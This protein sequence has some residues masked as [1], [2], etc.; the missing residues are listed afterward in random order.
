MNNKI[1]AVINTYNEQDNIKR[2]LSSVAWADE[3]VLCDMYSTDET[4]A[5]AKKMG[6]KV[7]YHKNVGFVEPARNFAISKAIGDWILIIDADEEI[8]KT[9]ADYLKKTAKENKDINYVEI[10]RKNIIFG[11]WMQASMWWPDYHPRFFRKG[12]VIWNEKIHSKPNASGKKLTLDPEEQNTIIHHHYTN[13]AQFISRM[14]RYTDI[15]AKELHEAGYEFQWQDLITKPVNEFLG[16]FF[17]NKGFNDGLHG[18]SLSFLQSFSHLVMYLKVWEL[19]SF[20]QI[21]IKLKDIEKS[22]NSS[23][24]ELNYWFKYSNLSSNP[25]LAALQKARNKLTS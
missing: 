6:A 15:Q 24:K 22:T 14:N 11:K 4:V 8:P 19:E 10:P 21:D 2:V 7:V 1:S 16:R 17:A 5:I 12:S 13:I 18:L 3:I 9:L 23:G 25:L 20:K